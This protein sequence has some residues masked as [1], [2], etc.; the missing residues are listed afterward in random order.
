MISIGTGLGNSRISPGLVSMILQP[1]G[2]LSTLIEQLATIF[3][4][5]IKVIRA[6]EKF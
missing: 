3:A 6:A 4:A 5:A 2:Q 1:S